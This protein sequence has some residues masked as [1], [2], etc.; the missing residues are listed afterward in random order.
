MCDLLCDLLCDLCECPRCAPERTEPKPTETCFALL[1]Q[2]VYV[3]VVPM[4]EGCRSLL[5]QA[6]PECGGGPLEGASGEAGD[7]AIS[8]LS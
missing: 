5:S 4:E 3:P 1:W 2:I 8:G 6:R 7:V